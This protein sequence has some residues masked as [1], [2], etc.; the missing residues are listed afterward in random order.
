MSTRILLVDDHQLFLEGLKALISSQ[1]HMEVVGQASNG[2]DAVKLC[3]Q[4]NPDVVI[5]DIS[6]PDQNGIEAARDMRAE[7]PDVKIIALS[8][9]KKPHF[10]RQ[11]IEAGA[12]GYVLKG[13]AFE[14]IA[15]AIEAVSSDGGYICPEVAGTIMD[16]VGKPGEQSLLDQLTPR[17]RQIIQ[18]IAE[19]KRSKEI[20]FDLL[21]SVKTVETYRTQ[22][23]R[24]LKIDSIAG[25]TK[26]A[27]QNGLTSEEF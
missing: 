23:M 13:C 25:L 4:L 14:E 24:K 10:V 20:A 27:I 1:D 26:F 18:L 17:E 12:N 11:M 22:L 2:R 16:L 5:M 15:T 19:G 6:M 7:F 9:H 8:M 21:V 3:R